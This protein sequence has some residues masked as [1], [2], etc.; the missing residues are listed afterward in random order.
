M[1]KLHL[2]LP[3]EVTQ[4]PRRLSIPLAPGLGVVEIEDRGSHVRRPHRIE[5]SRPG[6]ILE[7]MHHPGRLPGKAVMDNQIRL[8]QGSSQRPLDPPHFLPGYEAIRH[9]DIKVGIVTVPLATW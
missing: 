2:G 7:S 4:G 1:L 3:L 5:E 9:Q 6:N 8:L